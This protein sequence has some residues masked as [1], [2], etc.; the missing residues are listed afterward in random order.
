M[1]RR[2]VVEVCVEKPKPRRHQEEQDEFTRAFAMLKKKLGRQGASTLAP[3]TA[4]ADD[5]DISFSPTSPSA[6][7]AESV[8]GM[9]ASDSDLELEAPAAFDWESFGQADAG[10][11]NREHRDVLR[12]HCI[13]V[14]RLRR[15]RYL[16]MWTWVC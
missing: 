13:V 2:T 6:S 14:V 7:S 1:Q 5:S 11:T 8:F 4:G 15:L 16:V 9:M 3:T 12:S 10:A